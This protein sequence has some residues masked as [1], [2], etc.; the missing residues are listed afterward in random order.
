MTEREER[1]VSA[2]SLTVIIP[3]YNEE[4]SLKDVLP[5]VIDFCGERGIEVIVVNDGSTDGTADVFSKF[6]DRKNYTVLT[7]KVNRGYGGAIKTG[8]AAARTRYV[9]TIDADGQHDLSDVEALHKEI[10]ATGADMIVGSRRG[11]RGQSYYRSIGKSLIRRI[12]RVLMPLDIHDLN[13]G[14]KIY[15]REIGSRYVR[16]CPDSMA[17]SD[18]IALVFV[19]RR[20]LVLERPISIKP[21][22]AGRSTIGVGTAFDTVKEIL[23]I[24]VLFNPMRVFFPIAVFFLL[25]GVAW[26]LPLVLMGRGVSVGAMLGIVTGLIFLFLGL[27][28]EQLSLMRKDG[29]R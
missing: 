27:I 4:V 20:H 6:L 14:M 5:S 28:A 11:A 18:I 2:N 9:I 29:L 19:S 12:A 1:D 10:T 21:R 25:A 8:I 23:N 3:A 24:V 15:D 26:G 17:F 22:A 13:S 7:H 16:L